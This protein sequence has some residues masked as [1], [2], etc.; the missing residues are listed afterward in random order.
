MK[1]PLQEFL[2]RRQREIHH[3]HPNWANAKGGLFI[4]HSYKEMKPDDLSWWDD[5][6]F[7]LNRRRVWV[8]WRH[9]RDVYRSAVADRAREL[10]GED[11][12]DDWLL[13]GGTPEYRK[14][15]RSRKRI[16]SYKC[17]EPSAE[18][19]AYYERLWQLQKEVMQQGI[20]F[21]VRPSSR[22][23]R[24]A[25]ATNLELVA[26]LEVRNED[27]LAVV[28]RLARRLILGETTL[29]QEFGDYCYTKENWLAELPPLK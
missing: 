27:E 13:E 19:L 8:F 3:T 28:A 15:G 16:V 14:V 26:P 29:M 10:A 7:I 18:Q 17:R 22:R 12:G 6:G 11:P 5:V 1:D 24:T 21:E 23:T 20:D 9:P 2:R 25:S 4:P